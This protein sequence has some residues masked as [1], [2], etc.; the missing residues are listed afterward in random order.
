MHPNK[1]PVGNTGKINNR[2]SVV[3]A[4]SNIS[5]S[6]A[7]SAPTKKFFFELL[8]LVHSGEASVEGG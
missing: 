8:K 2:M 4:I 1:K 3:V 6:G 5:N 7:V